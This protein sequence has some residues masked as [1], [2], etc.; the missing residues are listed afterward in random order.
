MASLSKLLNCGASIGAHLGPATIYC[1]AIN[2][3][4]KKFLGS[5]FAIRSLQ[6]KK[7]RGRIQTEELKRPYYVS[8]SVCYMYFVHVQGL[9]SPKSMAKEAPYANKVF[10]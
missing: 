1:I 8:I 10:L 2:T 9:L 4:K 7:K 3:L 6:K 5:K